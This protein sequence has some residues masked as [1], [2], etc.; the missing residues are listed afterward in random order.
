MKY[1]TFIIIL[2]LLFLMAGLVNAL[3]Y[4]ADFPVPNSGQNQPFPQ[5]WYVR[6]RLD[7]CQG[8][9]DVG[10]TLPDGTTA[11]IVQNFVYNNTNCPNNECFIDYL[12]PE[13]EGKY[14]LQFC[15]PTGC[16][17]TYD[18]NSNGHFYVKKMPALESLKEQTQ[19]LQEQVSEHET[20]I[21]NIEIAIERIKEKLRYYIKCIF[22]GTGLTC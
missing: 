21:S 19:S 17:F 16:S 7:N 14:Q 3:A 2:C 9:C 18:P 4:L 12:T 22:H 5:Q 13:M 15:Y 20:R 6:I 10:V 8:S 11:Y 1:K